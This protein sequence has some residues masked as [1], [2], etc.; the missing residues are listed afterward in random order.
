MAQNENF[1]FATWGSLNLRHG[2][3]GLL[4]HF[5]SIAKPITVDLHYYFMYFFVLWFLRSIDQELNIDCQIFLSI[6]FCYD[7]YQLEK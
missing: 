6:N 3:R 4:H 2:L 5:C 7:F 1:L